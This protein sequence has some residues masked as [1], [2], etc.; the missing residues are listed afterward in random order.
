M[1]LNTEDYPVC[2]G[3][4]LVVFG[5]ALRQRFEHVRHRHPKNFLGLNPIES[6]K[7]IRLLDKVWSGRD[8]TSR[9]AKLFNFP[10]TDVNDKHGR[11]ITFASILD[12][13]TDP[14][15]SDSRVDS[16]LDVMLKMDSLTTEAAKFF[17][18]H[19]ETHPWGQF[20]LLE[21][22]VTGLDVA[23]LEGQGFLRVEDIRFLD[24]FSR[25]AGALSQDQVIAIGRH[26]TPENTRE[27]VL[28]EFSRWT[29]WTAQCLELL[30]RMS[31]SD[32]GLSN[33]LASS[34]WQC[35]SFARQ[36]TLKVSEERPA[37]EDGFNGFSQNAQEIGHDELLRSFK[38]A[39][40]DP[41]EIWDNYQVT[42]LAFPSYYCWEFAT[43]LA[44]S[45]QGIESFSKTLHRPFVDADQTQIAYRRLK[46]FNSLEAGAR[47]MHFSPDHRDWEATGS[48]T[49]QELVFPPD[50]WSG[51]A[52]MKTFVSALQETFEHIKT[53]YLDDDLRKSRS[54][55]A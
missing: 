17:K 38:Q 18:L 23:R 39:Q 31:S 3:A 45:L 14:F 1:N 51:V 21:P 9:K 15:I 47:P 35:W 44:G 41:N 49:A 46:H 54:P 40:R 8:Q 37:Y 4:S 6:D 27:S 19:K 7:T 55:S 13:G 24:N 12:G 20:D 52:N 34:I 26:E 16:V 29:F 36:C 10:V 22:L 28:Y 43:Y 2:C 50:L 25:I 48:R 42:T 53:A 32:P 11:R 5:Y 33:R 30:S